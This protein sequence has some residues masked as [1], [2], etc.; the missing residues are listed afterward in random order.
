[1]CTTRMHRC[2]GCT[3]AYRNV[4]LYRL[5]ACPHLLL[6]VLHSVDGSALQCAAPPGCCC[7]VPSPILQWSSSTVAAVAAQP[8]P[9]APARPPAHHHMLAPPRTHAPACSSSLM[10]RVCSLAL[11]PAARSPWQPPLPSVPASS[12]SSSRWRGPAAAAT[13]ARRR[14]RRRRARRP[15]TLTLMHSWLPSNP[16]WPIWASSRAAG[17]RPPC[18]SCH[19]SCVCLPHVWLV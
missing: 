1:M 5:P 2:E 8:A 19:T 11:A 7:T 3:T 16:C 6:C 10:M 4:P 12:S 13:S 9:R 18:R 14:R 15:P 17:A